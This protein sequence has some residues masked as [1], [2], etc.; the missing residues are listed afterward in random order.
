M[1]KVMGSVD[2][3]GR[4][5]VRLEGAQEGILVIVD[6]GFNSDLMLTRAAARALGAER[7]D[8]EIDVE[9]GTG[10]IARVL[11]GR[12]TVSWLGE[13]RLVQVMIADDWLWQAGRSGPLTTT[14]TG[15]LGNAQE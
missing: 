2:D 1:A 12:A 15:S 7:T 10:T 14:R 9:L 4:P 3:L 6:T 13:Q 8:R 5:V 11:R